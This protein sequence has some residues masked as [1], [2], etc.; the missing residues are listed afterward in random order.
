M[1][2]AGHKRFCFANSEGLLHSGSFGIMNSTEKVMDY[3]DHTR[4]IEKK[5]KEFVVSKTRISEDLYDRNYRNEW[6]MTADD[7]LEYGVVDSII[8]DLDILL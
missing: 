4:R 2:L 5:V 8:T 6:Y 7:M 3:I 1:T